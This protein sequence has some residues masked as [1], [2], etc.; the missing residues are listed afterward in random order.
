VFGDEDGV[1]VR[2]DWDLV[3]TN[4]L[5]GPEDARRRSEWLREEGGG[6]LEAAWEEFVQVS[7][8]PVRIEREEGEDVK[9]DPFSLL[10]DD[11]DG[12]WVNVAWDLVAIKD[13][14]GPE[15]AKQRSEWLR[16]EAGGHFEAAWEGYVD[17]SFE[18]VRADAEEDES[19]N[20][21]D[22]E[23]AS[24]T[25][26]EAEADDLLDQ[27]AF[28]LGMQTKRKREDEDEDHGIALSK[29]YRSDSHSRASPFL[30]RH[31]TPMLT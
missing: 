24:V 6:H 8:E 19:M 30:D 3:N 4:D 25:A 2:V 9:P 23:S 20:D 21:G 22:E 14:N 12:V 7:F 11:E 13:L 15:D 10:F 26:I 16:D 29:R 17:V 5:N 27:I 31:L 18:L 28:D 1:W